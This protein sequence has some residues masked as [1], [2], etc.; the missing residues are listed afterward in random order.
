MD[1]G[2]GVVDVPMVHVPRL[3]NLVAIE[4]FDSFGDLSSD[5][6]CKMR[7]NSIAKQ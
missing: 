4:S 3:A 5:R 6:G 1:G 2:E 7:V